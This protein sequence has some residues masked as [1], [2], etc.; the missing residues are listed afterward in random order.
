MA[1]APGGLTASIRRKLQE[2][3]T[4]EEIVQELVAG[5]LGQ[6]SAQRFVDRALAEDASGA[7]L[8]P[9]S[10]PPFVPVEGSA[11]QDGSAPADALDEF[12]QTRTAETQAAE[13]KVGRKT[14]WVG[15]ILM[16][17]GIV[18]T[19]VSYLMAEPG[20]RYTLMWGPVAF[21]LLVWGKAV[22]GGFANARTFAWFSAAASIA[23]PLVLTVVTLGVVAATEPEPLQINSSEARVAEAMKSKTT[24]AERYAAMRKADHDAF[25]ARRASLDVDGLLALWDEAADKDKCDFAMQMLRYTGEHRQWLA[26][27]LASRIHGSSESVMI[28]NA[29]AALELDWDT[30]AAIYHQWQNSD[31]P[32][33]KSAAT[34]AMRR[35]SR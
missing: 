28:C 25:E 18:I 34:I 11:A 6:V 14:L 4:P 8:P 30:G 22:I 17:S 20:Q 33:L 23:L 16:C 35:A 19:A 10:P 2:G 24:S 29:R 5:G 31:N 13:A 15:S 7:P 1:G 3:R 9:A 12:I 27:E 26:G 32:R 21:G